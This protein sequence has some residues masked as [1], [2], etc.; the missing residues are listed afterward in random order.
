MLRSLIDP[1]NNEESKHLL[2]DGAT[3]TKHVALVIIDLMY[4][5]RRHGSRS[6][7]RYTAHIWDED[8]FML[9]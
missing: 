4:S 6:T 7:C 1:F 3:Q 9:L 8:I 5:T 2:P